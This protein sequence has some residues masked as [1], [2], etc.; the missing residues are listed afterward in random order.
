MMEK[1]NSRQLI[2]FTALFTI[3]TS[4]LVNPSQL[5]AI[6]KQDAWIASIV[7]CCLNLVYLLLYLIL[8]KKYPKHNLIQM[9]E[10]ILGK[11]VG[12]FV[13]WLY[14]LFFTLLT[15]FLLKFLGEFM[16]TMILPSTP[17]WFVSITFV[18]VIM[19]GLRYGIETFA[20][21]TELFF[22]VVIIFLTVIIV[23]L[24]TFGDYS[25]LLPVGE[26]GARSIFLAGLKTSTF[27]EHICLLMTLSFFSAM[28]KRTAARSLLIGSMLGSFVLITFSVVTIIILGSYNTAHTLYPV[29][30]VVKKISIGDFF[31]R[32]EILMIG[33]WF[34]AVFAKIYITYFASLIGITETLNI[35]SY[36]PLIIPLGV[37]LVVYANIVYPNSATLLEFGSTWLSVGLIFSFF[38]PLLLIIIDWIKRAFAARDSMNEINVKDGP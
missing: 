33:V 27:Q 14:I 32:I 28:G 22:P 3:G 29:F 25:R 30:V 20:R 26:F 21:S 10:M 7:T 35:G 23:S 34:L 6:V 37:V 9:I 12:K 38:I 17:T 36:K 11:W 4:L 16:K 1:I 13:S 31:Q 2:I 8:I 19:I 15:I 18:V 24:F 5:S